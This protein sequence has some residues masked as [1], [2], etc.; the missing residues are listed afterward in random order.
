M[1]T[2]QEFVDYYAYISSKIPDD[3]RFSRMMEHSWNL[4]PDP[5]KKKKAN[6]K[7]F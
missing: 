1:V 6:T 5:K 2:K 4:K 7:W 3:D